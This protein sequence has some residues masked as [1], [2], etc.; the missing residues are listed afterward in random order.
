MTM[1]TIMKKLT[2]IS[3][4]MLIVV[5]FAFTLHF[6]LVKLT[7]IESTVCEHE[8]PMTMT[9]VIEFKSSINAAIRLFLLHVH[10]MVLW[11]ILNLNFRLLP[12]HSFLLLFCRRL[13]I[14]TNACW[15]QNLLW[16]SRWR[17]GYFL[18]FLI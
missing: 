8:S 10:R 3:E 18:K 16:L 2:L 7:L 14:L 5:K 11:F 13:I 17:S 12:V 9:L 1:E 6:I 4:I 15:K